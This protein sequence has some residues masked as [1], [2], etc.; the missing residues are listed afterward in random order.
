MGKRDLYFFAAN[1]D[2]ALVL[3]GQLRDRGWDVA[4]HEVDCTDDHSFHV[5]ATK[6]NSTDNEDLLVAEVTDGLDIQFDGS[7]SWLT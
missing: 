3:E 5:V 4:R 7:G 1:N 2:D 6:Q